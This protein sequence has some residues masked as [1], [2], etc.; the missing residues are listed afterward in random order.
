MTTRNIATGPAKFVSTRGLCPL[1]SGE[2]CNLCHPDAYNGPQDCPVV[3]MVMEDADL[4]E[5]MNRHRL[6]YREK[7]KVAAQNS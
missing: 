1:R 3:A 4:R 6:E 5:E 2:P 7:M